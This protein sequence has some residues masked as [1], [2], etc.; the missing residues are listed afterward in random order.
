MKKID[1]SQALAILANAGVIAGIIFLALELRQNNSLLEA[2]TSFAQFSVE[3]ERRTRLLENRAGLLEA[4]LKAR[5]GEE[6][7]RLER[8]QLTAHRLDILDSWLWQYRESLVGRLDPRLLNL[9]NWQALWRQDEGLQDVYHRIFA[10][11]NADFDR[12]IEENVI[13]AI[14]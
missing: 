5:S 10:R 11:R 3:R 8:A 13:N 1:V 6:L 12:Y 4:L 7:T 2:Q 14:E 9:D